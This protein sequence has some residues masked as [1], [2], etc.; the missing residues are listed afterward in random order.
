MAC[1]LLVLE[2][3]KVVTCENA[4]NAYEKRAFPPV[5]RYPK[6]SFPTFRLMRPQKLENVETKSIKSE[7]NR[8]KMIGIMTENTLTLEN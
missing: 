1:F 3:E 8:S 7:T 5:L 6:R 2:E 4:P